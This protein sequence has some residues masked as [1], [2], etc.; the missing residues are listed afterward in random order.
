MRRD[1]SA[2]MM[3]IGFLVWACPFGRSQNVY[4]P[5]R[6]KVLPGKR[7]KQEVLFV[8]EIIDPEIER[9]I[10]RRVVVDF[11]V[12]HDVTIEGR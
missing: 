11:H 1:D 9:E 12:H 5:A 8:E 10:R 2:V 7:M 6:T 4:F 3:L